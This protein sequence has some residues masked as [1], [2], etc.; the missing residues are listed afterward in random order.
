MEAVPR[1]SLNA[2]NL[3]EATSELRDVTLKAHIS[4]IEFC[5]AILPPGNRTRIP[6]EK[7]NEDPMNY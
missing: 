3:T 6:P 2:F 4:S 1:C 5:S 7:I